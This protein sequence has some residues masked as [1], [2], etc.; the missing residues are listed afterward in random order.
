M[1]DRIVET[2]RFL[3]FVLRHE[4]EAIGLHLD[5]EGWASVAELIAGARKR[6]RQLDEATIAEVVAGNDKR[7][8][9]LS[10]DG[11][12][13]RAVQG[14]S[15]DVD[16]G[17][18]PAVPP[19]LLY[20]GTATRFAEHI[21]REGLRPAGRQYVHLS[22]TAA[23]AARVGARHGRPVVLSVRAF[24]AHERGVVFHLSENQLWLVRSLPAEFLLW[25]AE[26]H[27][28]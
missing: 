28:S 9:A 17:L 3:S 27:V 7:R 1:R 13:I 5:R 22:A 14:H 20:H 10:A 4:P 21:R 23:A 11:T 16:L 8:F 2:S 12:R 19:A 6:G 26:A 24:E 25:P 15:I 18:A